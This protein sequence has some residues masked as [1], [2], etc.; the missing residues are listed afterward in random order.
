M[1]KNI[2][3]NFW[4]WLGLLALLLVLIIAKVPAKFGAFVFTRAVPGLSLAE[5]QGTF[6]RGS[7][8]T[9]LLNVN[10]D[11]YS[12]GRFEWRIKPLS[13]ITMKPCSNVNFRYQ[14]QAASGDV[15]GRNQR[16]DL[17]KFSLNAPASL[18]DLFAPANLAG[19]IS[20]MVD[21]GTIIGH[22][23]RS[24]A[25]NIS[26]RNGAYNDGQNWINLGSF[27]GNLAAD[28]RGGVD[29]DLVDLGGPVIADLDVNYNP[30]E[31]PRDEYGVLLKGEIGVRDSAHPDL[32]K[33]LPTL[34]ETIGEPTGRGYAI[35]WQQ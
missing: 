7:A 29:L 27:G 12:L 19:D 35:E 6:W 17:S 15:C 34:L 20:L 28:K 13:L 3:V 8:G 5:I 22:Q 32:Q 33:V 11:V 21:Q 1:Y 16:V 4:L 25:G 23:V 10:G 31:R 30:T 9:A 2:L 18:L 14:S 24:L 26:W